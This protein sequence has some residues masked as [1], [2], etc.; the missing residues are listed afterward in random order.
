MGR[1]TGCGRPLAQP[2]PTTPW[3][4]KAC[5]RSLPGVI[6]TEKAG[7]VRYLLGDGLGSIRQAIDG[8][9][10]VVAYTEFDPYGNSVQEG[11]QPYGFT[12]EWWQDEIDLLHLRARWYAPETGAFLSR[13]PV[14]SEPPYQYV[15]GNPVNRIDPSGY[16][17]A[18][19]GTKGDVICVDLFIQLE[20]FSGG[21]AAGDGR[22]F[23]PDSKPINLEKYTTGFAPGN[24]QG[25]G[26]ED[27]GRSR[28]YLYIYLDDNGN[29]TR[30]D[31][32]VNT[33]CVQIG[34]FGP[35]LKYEKLSAT[36]DSQTGDINV[37]WG[38]KNGFSSHLRTKADSINEMYDGQ[39]EA[40]SVVD[41]TSKFF[42]NSSSLLPDID[43]TMTLGR[44]ACEDTYYVRG[45]NR[46][47]FPSLEIYHYRNGELFYTIGTYPE[48]E[49]FDD[50]APF[51]G[52][53]PM[54]PQEIIGDG[55]PTWPWT[56]FE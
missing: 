25:F 41:I 47:P 48:T 2:R 14:E 56:L 3:M 50:F 44:F 24:T 7:Q 54:A 10:A 35:Y 30:S 55:L 51:W 31:L 49:D 12:G 42:T 46:D 38:L 33:S 20:T 17:P 5:R 18:P 13:D 19:K 6:V 26:Q 43:G 34:C 9:G 27:F 29:M 37:I 23:S 21:F 52:L 1:A 8:T 16:C 11:S 53:S 36:Q 40:G 4:L 45:L 28:A 32:Y 39:A 15:R 22:G